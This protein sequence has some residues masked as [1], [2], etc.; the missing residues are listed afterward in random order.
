MWNLL[1]FFSLAHMKL[2]SPTHV[3]FQFSNLQDSVSK[4]VGFAIVCHIIGFFFFAEYGMSI[5]AKC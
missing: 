1:D 5:L 3:R 4:T 2:P